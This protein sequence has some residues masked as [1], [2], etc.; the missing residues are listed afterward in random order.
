MDDNTVYMFRD[1]HVCFYIM[2]DG[3]SRQ[4]SNLM[5]TST[6]RAIHATITAYHINS[7]PQDQLKQEPQVLIDC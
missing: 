7:E 3:K 6:Q 1:N 4:S 2:M 5:L